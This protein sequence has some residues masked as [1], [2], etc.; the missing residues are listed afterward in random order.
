MKT[1][2]SENQVEASSQITVREAGARGGRATLE[3]QGIDFFKRIGH[4][5][6]KRTAQLYRELLKEFGKKGGRPRRPTLN[7]SAGGR[8]RD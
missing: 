5:G 7:E 6:G 8:D 3:N 4:R 2:K 1:R